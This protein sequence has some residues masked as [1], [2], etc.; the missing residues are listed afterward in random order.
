[1]I[2][3]VVT[4]AYVK[5]WYLVF[6]STKIV[7]AAYDGL[8]IIM[9]DVPS[10][11]D[12]LYLI[13]DENLNRLCNKTNSL[14]SLTGTVNKEIHYFRNYLNRTPK[15]LDDMVNLEKSLSEKDKW[16]L[17][18]PD[19]A[20][21]HMYGQDGEYNIKFVSSDGKFEAVYNKD[22]ILLTDKNDPLNMGTYNYSS[23]NAGVGADH[24]LLDVG[25]YY[26]WENIEGVPYPGL[27]ITYAWNYAVIS[28]NDELKNL[29][30]GMK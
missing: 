20:L 10:K 24:M 26:I 29:W 30:W 19:K 13:T 5:K 27:S 7:S 2:D 4:N 23:P 17:L 15:T 14:V 21:Y 28:I 6:E 12:Y 11:S 1:M 18:A 8:D 25:P 16:V 22:G 3:E 9:E